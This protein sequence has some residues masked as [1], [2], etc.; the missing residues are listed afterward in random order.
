MMGS[1]LLHGARLLAHPQWQRQA[2][3]RAGVVRGRFLADNEEPIAVF[4]VGMRINR[5]RAV[6]HWWRVMF[7][8]PRMLRE[9]AADPDSGLLGYRLFGGPGLRQVTLVQYWRKAGD[10]RAFAHDAAR[11]HHPEQQRFWEKYFAGNGAVGIW[12]EM[13]SVPKGAY[14]C[15]YGDMPA[16]GIGAIRGLCPAVPTSEHGAYRESTEPIFLAQTAGKERGPAA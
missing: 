5:W 6:P 13:F 16:G 11:T 9:L 1:A 3:P 7:A 10:I 12:H 8:M 4:L 14:Q 2:P 15:L